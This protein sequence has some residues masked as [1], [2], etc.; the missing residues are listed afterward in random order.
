MRLAPDLEPEPWYGDRLI[1][2]VLCVLL[3]AL[4]LVGMALL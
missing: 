2:D 1:Y 3:P 4:A